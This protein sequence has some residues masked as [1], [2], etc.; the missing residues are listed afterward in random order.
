MRPLRPK[1]QPVQAQSGRL[2]AA[3]LERGMAQKKPST[4]PGKPAPDREDRL[5]AAL[6]ANLARRKAQAK[7]R[8][9]QDEGAEA[10]KTGKKEG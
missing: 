4:Q 3:E 9:G 5:K 10:G 7:A 6:K 2:S 1:S 8:A